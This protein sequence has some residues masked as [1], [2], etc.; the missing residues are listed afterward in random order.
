MTPLARGHD[1]KLKLNI[2]LWYLN[3]QEVS[4]VCIPT[5]TSILNRSTHKFSQI[6]RHTRTITRVRV[7]KRHKHALTR[8]YKLRLRVGKQLGFHTVGLRRAFIRWAPAGPSD[9][10]PRPDTQSV[11]SAGQFLT[12][13]LRLASKRQALSEFQTTGPTEPS[14]SV[15][16]GRTG[17]P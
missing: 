13:G 7:V 8:G 2:M 12:A 4:M 3:L 6:H 17:G 5:H 11:S 15:G 10:G 16:S 1:A 9:D 14:V